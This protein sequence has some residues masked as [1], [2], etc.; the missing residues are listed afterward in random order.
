M[1]T[2]QQILKSYILSIPSEVKNHWSW[3]FHDTVDYFFP[4]HFLFGNHSLWFAWDIVCV[5]NL[6]YSADPSAAF[7]T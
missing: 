3:V 5:P 4:V 1:A 6:H 2:F 7:S